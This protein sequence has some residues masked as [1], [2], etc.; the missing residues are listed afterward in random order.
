MP[1]ENASKPWALLGTGPAEAVGGWGERAGAGALLGR[2]LL[3]H[4]DTLG[5]RT[6]PV[7]SSKATR[8]VFLR[9][10]HEPMMK[11]HLYLQ[12]EPGV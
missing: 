5:G 10:K 2:S 9:P 11:S 8:S 4:P 12:I 7:F 1:S 6:P 3:C